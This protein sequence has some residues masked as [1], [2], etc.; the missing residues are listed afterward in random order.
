[1]KEYVFTLSSVFFS[2]RDRIL[3][4][5]KEYIDGVEYEYFYLLN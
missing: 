2:D 1:M 3:A 4:S 5:W